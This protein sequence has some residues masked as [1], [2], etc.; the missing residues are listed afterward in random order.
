M[1]GGRPYYGSSIKNSSD[2]KLVT[3]SPGP[4]SY[5]PDPISMK[6]KVSYGYSFGGRSNDM[7]Y[8]NLGLDNYDLANQSPDQSKNYLGRVKSIPGPGAY[9]VG[10]SMEGKGSSI[11]KSPRFVNSN[12]K[13]VSK[14]IEQ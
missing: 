13:L 5:N 11:S 1:K 8:S 4:G 10:M 3:D 12:I 14:G 2:S 6:K 7:R 9:N